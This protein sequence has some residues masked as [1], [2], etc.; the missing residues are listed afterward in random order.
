MQVLS[1]ALAALRNRGS[2]E[3]TPTAIP[4]ISAADFERLV[5]NGKGPMVVEFFSP[6]CRA[7]RIMDPVI[8]EVAD[9][10]GEDITFYKVNVLVDW[11]LANDM[12]VRAVPEFFMYENGSLVRRSYFPPDADTIEREISQ[13]FEKE[14]PT[15]D[16]M[17]AWRGQDVPLTR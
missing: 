6:E 13:T 7:C 10:L 15:T 14:E 8:H 16:A 9:R 11:Q 4:I 2:E 17:L 5:L 1:N 12:N 3:P